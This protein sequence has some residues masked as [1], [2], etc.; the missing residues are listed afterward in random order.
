MPNLP[1][2]NTQFVVNAVAS[3]AVVGLV[4]YVVRM[5]GNAVGGQVGD[6]AKKAADLID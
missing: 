6:I 1:K 2:I 5:A 4:V 3:V